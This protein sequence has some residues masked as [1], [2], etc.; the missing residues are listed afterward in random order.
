MV[1]S[2]TEKVHE[3]GLVISEERWEVAVAK[4][5]PNRHQTQKS[6]HYLRGGLVLSRWWR[7]SDVRVSKL[8]MSGPP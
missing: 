7:S 5:H 6:S 4:E 8:R 3:I 1:H 2:E